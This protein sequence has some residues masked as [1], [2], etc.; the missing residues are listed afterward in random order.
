MKGNVADGK[1][2]AYYTMG[3]KVIA[4]ATLMSDPVAADVAQKLQNGTMCSK[5]EL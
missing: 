4:V 2:I 3:E 1:F 5:S